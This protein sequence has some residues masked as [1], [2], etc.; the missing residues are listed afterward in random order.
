[1]N[2]AK[3][4]LARIFVA[5][6]GLLCVVTIYNGNRTEHWFE[7]P[8][9]LAI[10]DKHIKKWSTEQG[11]NVY[12]YPVLFA[13]QDSDST[14]TCR[15]TV[16]ADLNM[17]NP[18]L[19]NPRPDIVVESSR[20]RFQAYWLDQ[21]TS[22]VSVNGPILG[23]VQLKRIP[24]TCNWKYKDN[25]WQVRE[26]NTAS[27][28][29]FEKVKARH[30]L[31]GSNFE[32][33]FHT[34]D[35]QAVAQLCAR[36]G[37]S[38]IETYLV[39]EASQV[40]VA[41]SSGNDQGTSM[42]ALYKD[43][44]SAVEFAGIPNLL[45]DDEVGAQADCSNVAPSFV[46]RYVAWATQ[47]T[48]SPSQYHVAGALTILS[49]ILSPHV[50]LPTAFGE[51]KC[52]LWFMILADTTQ[53]R[54]T[55]AMRMAIK[56]AKSVDPD[57]LL[58]NSGSGEGIVAALASRNG[59]S[60]VFFRDEISGFLREATEKRYM[61]GI[62]ESLTGFYDGMDE[63]RTLRKSVLEI[64]DPY[65]QILCGG[66]RTTTIEL[67]NTEHISSGFLPRF[68]FVLGET[69]PEDIK[70]I[71]PPE[72][73]SSDLRDSL[74]HYLEGMNASY[75]SRTNSG[76]KPRD[77]NP[78]KMKAS[79]DAWDRMRQLE[80]DTRELGLSSDNPNIFSPLFGRLKNSIIKVAVLLA[81]DRAYR[82]EH[83]PYL[84]LEDVLKAISYSPMWIESMYQVAGGIEDKPTKDEIRRT[85]V[86]QFIR[87]AKHG[88]MRGDVM[89]RFRLTAREMDEIESTLIQRGLIIAGTTGRKSTVYRAATG[90]IE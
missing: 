55:T 3:D 83:D 79:S 56:L 12:F 48:D 44:V 60:S 84:E 51:F 67:L 64:E 68:M 21:T 25:T 38:I 23:D 69:R 30:N 42:G 32:Q 49:V 26:I 41:M 18:V 66:I 4:F 89:R 36:L 85:R 16:C 10:V 9:E 57:V 13:K 82:D 65:F 71:G 70:A 58:T 22:P 34:C 1:M 40:D 78:I 47:C 62:L 8:S 73:A 17:V 43:A 75:I 33:L 31:N 80:S 35:R 61:S 24:A 59:K 28:D 29:T 54:K 77:N 88:T 87:M 81:A 2:E 27:L 37:C 11:T 45:T 5:N 63:K 19:V 90:E 15:P 50:Q 74:I 53:T 7:Y 76:S 72:Q 52:N 6:T 86:E 14:P 39:L 46:D 20:G